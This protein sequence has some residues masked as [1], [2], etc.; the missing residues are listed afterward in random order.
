MPASITQFLAVVLSISVILALDG[1]DEEKLAPSMPRREDRQ[2][3]DLDDL[4]AGKSYR[5]FRIPLASWRS[6]R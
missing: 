4:A 3:R 5:R 1:S 6:W 2:G